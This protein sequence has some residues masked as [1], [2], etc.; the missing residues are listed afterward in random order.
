MWSLPMHKY[1]FISLDK[2]SS[3][4]IGFL[5]ML[6]FHLYNLHIER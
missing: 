4:V 1:S 5:Y 2:R 3:K 6:K